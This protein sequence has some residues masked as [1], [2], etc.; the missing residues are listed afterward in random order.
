MRASSTRQKTA[1]K[2]L[3]NQLAYTLIERF[4]RQEH[5]LQAIADSLNTSG[6]RTSKGHLFHPTT[7]K[8]LLER[9]RIPLD[10]KIVLRANTTALAK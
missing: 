6:F 1:V 7:V 3:S 4:D 5:T 2:L 9:R 8:R 10:N